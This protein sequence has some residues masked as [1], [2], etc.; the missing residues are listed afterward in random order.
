MEVLSERPDFIQRR[1]D[2]VHGYTAGI[3]TIGEIRR[4]PYHLKIKNSSSDASD[5]AVRDL[6]DLHS[7]DWHSRITTYDIEH[8]G[9]LPAEETAVCTFMSETQEYFTSRIEELRNRVLESSRPVSWRLIVVEDVLPPVV[10]LLGCTLDLDPRLFQSHIGHSWG[11]Q[12]HSLSPSLS[13]RS[14]PS[15]LDIEIPFPRLHEVTHPSAWNSPSWRNEC[16]LKASKYLQCRQLKPIYDVFEEKKVQCIA[17]EHI[18]ASVNLD[19]GNDQRWRVLV[20][21]PSSVREWQSGSLQVRKHQNIDHRPNIQMMQNIQ[22]RQGRAPNQDSAAW[23]AA[24][25]SLNDSGLDFQKPSMIIKSLWREALGHWKVHL[26]HVARAVDLLSATSNTSDDETGLRAQQQLRAVIYEGATI[27]SDIVDNLLRDSQAIHRVNIDD[28]ADAPGVPSLGSLNGEFV[29]VKKQLEKHLP[30]LE[31]NID[32]IRVKQQVAL[33][34][35]QLEESRK[36]IQQSETIKRLTILAFVYIPVQ[37]AASI[38][39]MN[40]RE[41]SPTP[42]VWVFVVTALVML[43]VTM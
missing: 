19:K 28:Y 39:G 21:F 43:A 22:D 29:Q 9:R 1:W 12:S 7:R 34:T 10:E 17:Y 14:N 16:F 13:A 18:S 8:D 36:A 15:T 38:F 37:T 27:L 40:A 25:Q 3:V 31:H 35:T 30:T 24:L 5:L 23:F 11:N 4:A 20:M 26:V 6:K 2:F 32:I 33:A 41:L 42:S